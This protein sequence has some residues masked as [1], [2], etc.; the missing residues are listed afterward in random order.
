M[1]PVSLLPS[2]KTCLCLCVN[3]PKQR[4]TGRKRNC[5]GLARL[6]SMIIYMTFPVMITFLSKRRTDGRTDGRTNGSK[7][8]LMEMHGR[9]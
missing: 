4:M 1:H 6:V 2:G 7:K 9:D 5:S 3:F 8:S